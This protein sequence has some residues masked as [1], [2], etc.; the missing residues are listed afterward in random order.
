MKRFLRYRRAPLLGVFFVAVAMIAMREQRAACADADARIRFYAARI[1]GPATYP[2][3]A[4]LGASYLQKARE[5]GRPEYYL[6]A[7][8]CLEQSLR[9]QR[10]YEALHWLAAVDNARHKFGEALPLAREAVSAMPADLDAQGTL[11]DAYLG[12]QDHDGAASVLDGMLRR[13]PS[14]AVLARLAALRQVEGNWEAAIKAM[15]SA[16]VMA[17]GNRAPAETRA[18]CQVQLGFLHF[19]RGE[20]KAADESYAR[21]LKIFPG[22]HHALQHLAELRQ[23]QGRATQPAGPNAPSAQQGARAFWSV[24]EL[25]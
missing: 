6:Q 15:E 12:L 5:T 20:L 13:G 14:T 16:S 7:E 1:G 9:F 18:W 2:A 4:R 8:R 22:Y 19:R 23:A 10:N 11:F 25:L 24:P 21:A 3:Y 17:E